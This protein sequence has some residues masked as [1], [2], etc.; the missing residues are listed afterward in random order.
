MSVKMS[1]GDLY[2]RYDY[3]VAIEGEHEVKKLSN[4]V[5]GLIL[6]RR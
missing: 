3:L 2:A 4:R 1:E 6:R 5:M